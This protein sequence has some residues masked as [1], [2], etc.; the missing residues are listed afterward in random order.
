MVPS[1]EA[2][3]AEATRMLPSVQDDVVSGLIDHRQIQLF[4][5]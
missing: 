3:R 4:E 1:A 5:G 2:T